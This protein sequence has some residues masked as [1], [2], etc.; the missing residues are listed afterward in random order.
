MLGPGDKGLGLAVR[1]KGS[2]KIYRLFRK[3][4]GEGWRKVGEHKS[5]SPGHGPSTGKQ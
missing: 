1:V 3:K 4:L 2:E 5:N